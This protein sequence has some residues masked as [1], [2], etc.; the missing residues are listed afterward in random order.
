MNPLS[1][2]KFIRTSSLAPFALG[3]LGGPAIRIA[4]AGEP[5]L[6]ES[7]SGDPAADK[8]VGVR[9]RQP[10]KLPYARRA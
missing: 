9:Y 8:L 4:R 5:G 3:G 7:M 1:R 2:R 6:N 10:W